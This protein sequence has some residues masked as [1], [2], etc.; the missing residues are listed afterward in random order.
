MD[1]DQIIVLDNGEIVG[2]GKHKDL[3]QTSRVYKEIA[4]SQLSKEELD[5]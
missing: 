3:L 2:L 5:G 1:S 4:N